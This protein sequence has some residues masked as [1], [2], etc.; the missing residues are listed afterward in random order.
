MSP[1]EHQNVHQR[2]AT[3]SNHCT[4]AACT[5][6]GMQSNLSTTDPDTC[7]VHAQMGD[8]LHHTEWRLY[9][10]W[11]IFCKRVKVLVCVKV[12]NKPFGYPHEQPHIIRVRLSSNNWRILHFTLLLHKAE[13]KATLPA[14]RSCLPNKNNTSSRS[15]DSPHSQ[16]VDVVLSRLVELSVWHL[17]VSW[18]TRVL[19]DKAM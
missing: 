17:K 13:K 10:K 5:H 2:P 16:V 3:T 15:S 7:A 19:K 18:K 1:I 4:A 11:N 6:P 9:L 12:K 8:C 14:Q